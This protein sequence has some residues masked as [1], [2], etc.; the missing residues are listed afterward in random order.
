MYCNEIIILVSVIWVHIKQ[1]TERY[2]KFLWFTFKKSLFVCWYNSVLSIFL[3]STENGIQ[4]EPRS[5]VFK[6]KKKKY[7]VSSIVCLYLL[8]LQSTLTCTSILIKFYILW[9]IAWVCM[10]FYCFSIVLFEFSKYY[11]TSSGREKKV[12]VKIA[13]EGK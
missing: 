10:C 7:S 5:A 9:E 12:F 1:D 3:F 2:S 4:F 8:H 11:K 6:Q 13:W